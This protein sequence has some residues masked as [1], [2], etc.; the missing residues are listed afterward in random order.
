MFPSQPASGLTTAGPTVI[1]GIY[2]FRTQNWRQLAGVGFNS[3]TD[4]GVQEY[5]RAQANAR[6]AGSVWLNAYNNHTCERLMSDA[7]LEAAVRANVRA[8]MPGLYYEVGDE[9]TAYGCAAEATYREMTAAIHSAD[10]AARTWTS[11]DEFNDPNIRRWPAGVPMAGTLDVL[12]FDIYPCYPHHP[13]FFYMI[14]DA[15]A[16]IHASHLS[17]P[18]WFELQDFGTNGWRWPTSA[19]L[20]HAYELWQGAGASG[21]FVYAWDQPPGPRSPRNVATLKQINSSPCC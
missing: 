14:R 7:Q 16:H 5:G 4:G 19:E 3:V 10:P 1:R 12:S 20:E 8:G 2:R 6:L 15:I 11:D 18:W 9:P 13:C 17:Q 21:Y